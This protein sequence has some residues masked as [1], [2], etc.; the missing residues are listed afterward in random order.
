M[1]DPKNKALRPPIHR[2]WLRLRLGKAYYAGRRY[3][4]WCSPRF[5]WANLRQEERLSCLYFSHA[6]PL[7]RHL[8][9]EDMELQKN[10]VTNLRLA[11]ARLDGLVLRP[12]ETFSYWKLIGKPTRRKGYLD[13]M[14]LFLGHIG[15]DVGGGLCQLSNLIFWMTLHTPLTVVERYRHSHDV[16]PDAG[17]TQPFGSGATCA[18]PHRDLMIRNGTEHPYRLA[19]Q[20]GKRE[21]EGA[22]YSDAP[23]PYTYQVY[24]SE[25]RMQ[26]EYWGGYTRHNVIRR[27]VLDSSGKLVGDEFV[28]ENHAIMMYHPLLEKGESLEPEAK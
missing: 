20:V 3:L 8:R 16:F 13:G 6:T 28:T 4:L 2:T 18:Y 19:L 23:Q 22:W 25:H 10:K 11:V 17:R 24:Q 15:S 1:V 9:G 14:V 7:Y 12:G 26:G 27:R 21:L 5:H